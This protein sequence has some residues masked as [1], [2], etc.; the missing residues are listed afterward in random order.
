MA[1]SYARE[2]DQTTGHGSYPP[3]IFQPGSSLCPLAQIEGKPILTV[4]VYCGPHTSP[5]NGSP[6]LG[7]H[8]PP[9][10]L[11]GYIIQGSPTC[12]VKC[13]DG[14]YRKVA[15]IG[16]SLDCGCKIVGGAKTV[17]AGANA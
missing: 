14:V 10:P 2:G 1:G 3:A 11:G 7:G 15:R 6:T 5:S 13:T 8:S 16:D 12:E 17:G 9:N 4:D